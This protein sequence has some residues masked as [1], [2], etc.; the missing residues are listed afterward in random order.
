MIK[1]CGS[2]TK[3]STKGGAR[4]RSRTG[5][6]KGNGFLRPAR[7]PIPPSGLSSAILPPGFRAV[8]ANLTAHDKFDRT[9]FVK[10]IMSGSK[11]F[12]GEP[13]NRASKKRLKIDE[14]PRQN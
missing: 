7:L 11:S 14:E 9:P 4:S 13:S 5:T 6:P 1:E 12:L 3:V 10:Y 2:A 8:N